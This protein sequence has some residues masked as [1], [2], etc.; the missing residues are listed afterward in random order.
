[1]GCDAG[2]CPMHNADLHIRPYAAARRA[3]YGNE[4]DRAGSPIPKLP[5]TGTDHGT[6]TT[7]A[8]QRHS[9]PTGQPHAPLY[10]TCV[11]LMS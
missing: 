7:T 5:P 9:P 11:Q 10:D 2:T 3:A 6:F 4:V 1:M 8:S